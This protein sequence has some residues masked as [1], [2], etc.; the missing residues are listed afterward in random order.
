[1]P[2]ATF[3][4]FSDVNT[5][6]IGGYVEQKS[7]GGGKVHTEKAVTV[8]GSCAGAGSGEF[9]MYLNSRN[10]EKFRMESIDEQRQ[11]EEEVRKFKEK[12][13][14]NK[15]LAEERV[16]KNAKKRLQKKQKKENSRKKAKGAEGS[17]T[18]GKADDKE[19]DEGSGSSGDEKEEE[20]QEY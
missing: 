14:L 8:M 13:D 15:K 1:M 9:H 4:V 11:K 3:Q 7:N 6:V 10:R 2:K 5:K 19:D 16:Q 17:K 12:L 18:D 20:G